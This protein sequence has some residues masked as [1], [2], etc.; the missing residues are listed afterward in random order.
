MKYDNCSQ[1]DNHLVKALTNLLG[2]DR[3]PSVP[4]VPESNGIVERAIKE[5]VRHLKCIVNTRRDHDD[6]A[7]MLPIAVRIMNAERH[8]GIGVA[9]AEIILPGVRLNR[10]LFPEEGSAAVKEGADEINSKHRKTEVLTW[11]K[12][13]Q[14]LQAA[15]IRSARGFREALQ[16]KVAEKAPEETIEFQP[17][18][19]VVTRPRGGKAT[20]LSVEWK[21]PY[22][23]IKQTTGTTYEVQDPA[24][25]RRYTK[26]VRE[27]APY[28]MGPD[29]DPRDTIAMDE[30]EVLVESILDHN[31]RNSTKKTDFD[32][33][34]RWKNQGPEE[35]T[36]IPY[37]EARPLEAFDMS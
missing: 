22:R 27:M 3:N 34:V 32:F 37:I 20:K 1:F 18:Q 31:D 35:D 23:I 36:W 7:A 30:V 2:I 29:E 21:G 13:L 8:A 11:V 4:F 33:L 16:H 19:W 14:A 28:N 6:W 26:H 12:H 24:D 17:G 25:L 5:V 9:P 10:N 15:A